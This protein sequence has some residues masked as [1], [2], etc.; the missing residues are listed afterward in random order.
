MVLNELGPYYLEDKE[1]DM[2]HHL[3]V[4]DREYLL[5][6][7]TVFLLFQAGMAF[8]EVPL[9]HTSL[10][11]AFVADLELE[12]VVVDVQRQAGNH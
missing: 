7:D 2:L 6:E 9:V 3:E 11:A 1:E 4:E 8:D 10:D 12:V 5:Q